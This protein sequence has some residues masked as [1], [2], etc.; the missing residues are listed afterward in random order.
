MKRLLTIV[1]SAMVV[2]TAAA[3]KKPQQVHGYPINP[4]PF[5]AVKV[6]QL[7]TTA[8]GQPES[9]DTPRFLKV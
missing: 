3:A 6:T 4:V 9:D 8:G 2:L 7:G 1:L 5:T